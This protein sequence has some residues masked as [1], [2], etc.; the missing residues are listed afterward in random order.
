MCVCSIHSVITSVAC[1]WLSPFTLPIFFHFIFVFISADQFFQRRIWIKVQNGRY[2]AWSK[3]DSINAKN[4]PFWGIFYF[5]WAP[6]W[7]VLPKIPRGLYSL[8]V[9]FAEN[10]Q[11]RSYFGRVTR[12]MEFFVPPPS[13]AMGVVGPW[14]VRPPPDKADI[15][16]I[17]FRTW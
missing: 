6:L 3:I 1:C 11:G 12:V 16:R 14:V 2:L 5:F 13:Q 9:F 15:F 4:N 7:G 17:C 10:G 8:G